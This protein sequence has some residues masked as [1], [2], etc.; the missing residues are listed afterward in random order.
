M[1]VKYNAKMFHY[2]N[3]QFSFLDFDNHIYQRKVCEK[4]FKKFEQ[5]RAFHVKKE[6]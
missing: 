1:K 5:K 3:F 2:N 4:F 6:T